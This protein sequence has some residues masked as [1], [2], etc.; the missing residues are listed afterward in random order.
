MKTKIISDE[1][2]NSLTVEALD[3]YIKQII[4]NYIQITYCEFEYNKNTDRYKFIFEYY[5]L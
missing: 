4:K 2:R 1:E 3:D 5:G